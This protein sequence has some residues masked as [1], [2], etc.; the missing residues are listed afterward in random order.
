MRSAGTS[1]AYSKTQSI[2]SFGPAVE[3]P[4]GVDDEARGPERAAPIKAADGAAA[5]PVVL[6]APAVEHAPRQRRVVQPQRRT[7]QHAA[8]QDAERA[9]HGKPAE[10]R[11][12]VPA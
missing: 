12:R 3:A 9:D 6:T 7:H 2:S 5:R 1:P 4:P 10:L 11:D 8:E